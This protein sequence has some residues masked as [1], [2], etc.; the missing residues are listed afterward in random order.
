[1]QKLP[2]IV[3]RWNEGA[4]L[5]NVE[6]RHSDVLIVGAGPAGM[7]AAVRA[8]EN[9]AKVT[10]LDDNPFCG[11]QI[12]RNKLNRPSTAEASIWFR[13][14]KTSSVRVLTGSRVIS[15]DVQRRTL[16][17]ETGAEAFEVRYDTLILATGAREFFLPFPGWTLPNI[18]GVGALQA[19]VKSGLPVKR[20]R[21]VVAGS[22][23]LLL[24]A[25]AYFRKCGAIVPLIAEQS[26]WRRILGFGLTL[27]R[28]P[29]K[30]W[31]ALRLRIS[32][33]GTRYF[34]GCWITAAEGSDKLAGVRLRRGV[35]TWVERCD[36]LAVAYGL[37][38]NTELAALLGCEISDGAVRV[39]QLQQTSV[40]NIYCAGESTG[41]GGLDLS[42]GEGEVAGYAATGRT[43]LAR[44]LFGRRMRNARFAAALERGFIL[45]DELRTLADTDTIICRCEDVTL[46][47]LQSADSWRSAKLHVRCGMGPCQGRVCGPIVQFLFG[48]KPESVRPPLFPARLESLIS[49]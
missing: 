14:L 36:Y 41:I 31:Q 6:T 45:R 44:A 47:Q 1:L 3:P 34:P 37:V 10:V 39:N 28:N 21:I 29:A 8:A 26:S 9:G 2:D 46:G 33:A 5:M 17:A 7:A 25:A 40:P 20:K 38:P 42:L 18:M 27:L 35:K 16:L 13:D 11:G 30:L 19:L 43:Q 15:A 12:W 48:W 49:Q 22:G 24:A 4:D 23:P 32:L